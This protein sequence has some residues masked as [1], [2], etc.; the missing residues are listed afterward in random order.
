M[1]TKIYRD[2]FHKDE[3]ERICRSAGIPEGADYIEILT[4]TWDYGFN[5][6]PLNDKSK[7]YTIDEFKELVQKKYSG[8]IYYL[9]AD[10]EYIYHGSV[11]SI[12]KIVSSDNPVQAL[13]KELKRFE[14]R[15]EKTPVRIVEKED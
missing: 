1:S 8:K 9:F 6:I 15:F 5:T 12:D 2:S 4:A 10:Y 13:E 3:F 14:R 11:F 7:M